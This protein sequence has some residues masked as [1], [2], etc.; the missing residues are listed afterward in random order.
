MIRTK[1]KIKL[2]SENRKTPFYS[3]YRPMFCFVEDMKTS[4]KIILFDRSCFNPGD[5]GI[6]EILFLNKEFLGE[7]FGSGSEF[8]FSEGGPPMGKGKIINVG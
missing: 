7:N 6:V 2:F 8:T 3:G 1:A 4:G 5:E